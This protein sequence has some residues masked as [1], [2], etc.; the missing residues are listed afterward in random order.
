MVDSKAFH[1]GWIIIITG[2]AVLFTCL[3][4][5]RFAL[6]MLLPSMG[7]GLGLSYSQM[8][9]ISTG[10][11]I[12]YLISVI[13]AGTLAGRIG[14]R[15][16]ISIGLFLVAGSMLVIG[17]SKG[18]LDVLWLYMFTGF[19]SG[20]ANVALMGLIAYWFDQKIRGRAAGIMISGSGLAIVFAGLYVPFINI[21]FGEQGWRYAWWTM[22]A[23]SVAVAAA[24]AMLIRNRPADKGM[25][26]MGYQP[27]GEMPSGRLSPDG[28]A[29]SGLGLLSYLGV[30]YA[31][32]GA[33]YMVYATFIVTTLVD[34]RGY[35]E[36]VAGTFWAV[37]GAL[38]IFSGPVFGW[39]S[40]RLGR[41]LG[42]IAVFA[43][44]TLSYVLVAVKLQ[45]AYLYLSIMLYGLSAWSIPTIMAAAVGDYMGPSRAAKAFG[46]ITVF[47][48]VGQIVGP[49]SAG[50][51]AEALG[52]FQVAFWMC[53]ALTALAAALAFFIRR[54]QPGT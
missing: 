48:S 16:T 20:L 1:Y 43:T 31:L 34:E 30:I 14:A 52:T 23:I 3:G 10:N 8:G 45:E 13:I 33:T 25:E 51:L 17:R 41:K 42:M 44:F 7:A 29:N 50:F 6:G 11:F 2:V 22:G 38:S 21:Q 54:P 26:P 9:L 18:F 4:L 12:G 46:F 36:D 40:D 15:R 27:G 5:G 19:G 28:N 49:A 35:T 32:F 39:V 47:F 37:V 24:A 53:S